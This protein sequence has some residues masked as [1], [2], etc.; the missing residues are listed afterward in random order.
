MTTERCYVK[1]YFENRNK[2][3]WDKDKIWRVSYFALGYE[4]QERTRPPLKG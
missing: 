4:G 1:P 3:F 2:E